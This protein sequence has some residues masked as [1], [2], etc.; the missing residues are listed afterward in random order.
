M[1][2]LAVAVAL[3]AAL[4]TLDAQTQTAV[5]DGPVGPSPYTVMRG[6]QK[7]FAAAGFAFGG[8]SGVFAESAD[9]IFIAQRG[10]FRLPDP[11]PPEYDGY[12]GSLKMNV[13]TLADRRVWKNCLYTLDRNGRVKELWTQWDNL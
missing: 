10:E 1:H 2:R 8:N 9:R 5:V 4:I 7:P 11:L 13:L 3:L 12:A 6:W